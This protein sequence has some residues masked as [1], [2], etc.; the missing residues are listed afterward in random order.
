MCEIFCSPYY[1]PVSPLLNDESPKDDPTTHDC[2]GDRYC[3]LLSPNADVSLD[4]YHSHLEQVKEMS[5]RQESRLSNCAAVSSDISAVRPGESSGDVRRSAPTSVFCV[6]NMDRSISQLAI[7][8]VNKFVDRVG[9][10][11]AGDAEPARH[12]DHP[13]GSHSAI[14]VTTAPAGASAL[15]SVSLSC[16]SAALF[17]PPSSPVEAVSLPA[18]CQRCS[19]GQLLQ[20][21]HHSQPKLH[22]LSSLSSL[23]PHH[24]PSFRR[25]PS[26]GPVMFSSQF[27]RSNSIAGMSIA[28][29]LVLFRWRSVCLPVDMCI[30]LAGATIDVRLSCITATM[31]WVPCRY[32]HYH[33]S[34]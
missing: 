29:V 5:R 34:C 30:V 1:R 21:A 7:T 32:S 17:P 22:L 4:N 24:L 14:V 16:P 9:G 15:V 23:A 33:V 18:T 20:A 19:I 8:A 2:L 25:P 10:R 6:R 28:P 26:N 31:A 12:A 3:C 27:V 13:T 11:C